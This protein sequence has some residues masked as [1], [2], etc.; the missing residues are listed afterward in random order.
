MEDRIQ[1]SLTLDDLSDRVSMTPQYLCRL[2]KQKTGHTPIEHFTRLK[3]Q[4]ACYLLDMTSDQIH[5]ISR[6]IGFDDPYYFTRT[7]KR[8]MGTPPREY[9]NRQK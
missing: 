9:R 1:T 3:I 6:Q 4:R 8:I 5:E 7:F 2:F